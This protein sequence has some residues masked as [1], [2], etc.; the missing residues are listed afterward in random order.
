MSY[1]IVTRLLLAAALALCTP[2]V[3]AQEGTADSG[4]A[5]GS[6]EAQANN[7]LADF[8]A[9]NLHNFYIPELSETDANANNFVLR[10]AQP[11]GKW[12]MRASLPMSRVPTRYECTCC[13]AL[14]FLSARQG[15]LFPGR[16]DLGVRPGERHL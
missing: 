11:F 5:S 6:A 4:T 7:P 3:F 10:Y 8:K 16:A 1:H 12:L 15:Q 14:L 13:P 9:F 2:L